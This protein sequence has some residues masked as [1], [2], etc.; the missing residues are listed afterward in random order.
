MTK[1]KTRL[2]DVKMGSYTHF[3][4]ITRDINAVAHSALPD[5]VTQLEYYLFF[6][7]SVQFWFR[8]IYNY[9][10]ITPNTYICVF[11]NKPTKQK[12]EERQKP[13]TAGFS[14]FKSEFKL[15]ELGNLLTISVCCAS[16][17]YRV[18][19]R[20]VRKQHRYKQ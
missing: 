13:T 11:K 20:K 2:S 16:S 12:M 8:C 19:F 9:N 4:D 1:Q 5:I 18:Q 3:H 7:F 6:L 17:L 10:S 15:F 14:S